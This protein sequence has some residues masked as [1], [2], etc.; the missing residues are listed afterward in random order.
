MKLTK[1]D[2]DRI[3][4]IERRVKDRNTAH[5]GLCEYGREDVLFLLG[6][7]KKVKK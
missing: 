3:K 5:Y 1:L 7:I 4:V 6:L 2:K